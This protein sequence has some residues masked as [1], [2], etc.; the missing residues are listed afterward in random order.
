MR[1][2]TGQSMR[3]GQQ[4]KLAPRMIQSMEI[5]Q[6]PLAELEQRIEEELS[7]N[8]TLEMIEIEPEERDG[9]EHEDAG[10]EAVDDFERLDSF[11]ESNPEAAENAFDERSRQ[12]EREW[13]PGYE[14]GQR[15]RL[16][17]EGDAKL[18]AMANTPARTEALQDQLLRQW[19]VVDVGD[20]LRALGRVLISFLEDDGYLR[21]GFDEIC[22]KSSRPA[23]WVGDWPCEASELEGALEAVQLLVEPVGVGARDARECLLLQLDAALAGELGADDGEDAAIADRE[24]LEL[25]R[26]VVASHLED[27]MKNRLPKIADATGYGI[28]EIR[29]ALEALRRLSLAPAGRLT[30]EAAT[31]VVPDVIVEYD[32]S[33]DRY[34]AYLND[35][36]LPN[37]QLNREYALMS[38]DRGVE[39]RDRDFLKKS[40]SNAQW[41]MDAVEQRRGTVLRVVNVVLDEQ[42]EFFDYGPGA[43]KPLPMTQVADQLGIHVA[44]VSRAVS[45]K[46]VQTPRG[47]VPLRGFFTGGLSTES[48]EDVS[49]SAVKAAITELIE[50]E[51]KKKP[52]SDEAMAKA[53]KGRGIEIARRTVAKYRDQM[54]V[55]SARMRK[56]F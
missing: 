45:E 9:V 18:E 29:N 34:V 2:E 8:P 43:L 28:D 31:P 4:M 49:S 50:G 47:V 27:L 41:L 17:G 6:M 10:G 53:L 38:K 23:G 22:E 51:D 5:L 1:F 48:G 7:S 52:L 15:S 33:G 21:V 25:A 24:T 12:A 13:E 56:A 35:T 19:G 16:S 20:R 44:T 3:M 54:G 36:R 55:A 39:K 42:R 32:D 30:E 26:T 11:E 40:I 14:A 37:L 46:W